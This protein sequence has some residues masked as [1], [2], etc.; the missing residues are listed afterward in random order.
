MHTST[1]SEIQSHYENNNHFYYPEMEKLLGDVIND[2]STEITIPDDFISKS[3]QKSNFLMNIIQK[4]KILFQKLITNLKYLFFAD[5]RKNYQYAVAKIKDAY[6]KKVDTIAKISNLIMRN[7]EPINPLKK[8]LTDLKEKIVTLEANIIAEKT[9]I[10]EQMDVKNLIISQARAL[11]TKREAEPTTFEK[12]GKFFTNMFKVEPK[13]EAEAEAIEIS[14]LDPS[15]PTNNLNEA[16]IA[17]YEN[18]T[19][20]ASPLIQELKQ[21]KIS[22]VDKESLLEQEKIKLQTVRTILTDCVNNISLAIKQVK[23]ELNL[24][25]FFEDADLIIPDISETTVLIAKKEL[26]P[27]EVQL[28]TISNDIEKFVNKDLAILMTVLLK[29]LPEDAITSWKCDDQGKFTLQLK[30]EYRIWM[31]G[32]DPVGGAVNI[33]GYET[34][35]KV[36][37]RLCKDNV[38]FD[39]GVNSFVKISV[40][41]FIYPSFDGIQYNNRTDIRIGG[42]Y[43]GQTQWKQKNFATTKKDW[44]SKAVVID[45]NYPGGI[46][47]FLEEK[48]RAS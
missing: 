44:E 13:K 39:T 16:T 47:A 14:E 4:I 1:T 32:D 5:Y 8:Q 11:K 42:T 34:N 28:Q 37:G 45:A 7:N 18:E 9:T 27:K 46:K 17:A 12:V 38:Y 36:E 21:R 41:G 19:F 48:I 25:N 15:F 30:E 26:T 29:R 40:L 22:L 31:P 43:L 3:L 24:E 10:Q 23:F 6:K 33:F 35:G 2:P 20:D